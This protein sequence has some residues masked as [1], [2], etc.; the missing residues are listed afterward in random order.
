MNNAADDTQIVNPRLAARVRGKMRRNFRK[1]RVRQPKLIPI[2]QRFL[3]ESVNHNAAI[4]PTMLWA[5][6]LR[7]SGKQL[8]LL[9]AAN[10]D[11]A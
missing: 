2:H 3:S 5:Q 1:L 4:T 7:L 9:A 10:A 11:C 8:L 6:T